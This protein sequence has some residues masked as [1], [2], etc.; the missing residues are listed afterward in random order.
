MGASFLV[1]SVQC[2]GYLPAFCFARSQPPSTEAP[3]DAPRPTFTPSACACARVM[4]VALMSASCASVM[5]PPPM[6][7]LTSGAAAAPM[8]R[9]GRLPEN[10]GTT[11]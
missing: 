11:Y 6:L 1:F 3:A 8:I 5:V 4:P 9:S 10:S 7:A 2:S